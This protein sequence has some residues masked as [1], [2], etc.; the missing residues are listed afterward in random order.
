MAAIPK[1]EKATFFIFRTTLIM[2]TSVTKFK[3]DIFDIWYFIIFH[4][5]V[6]P[7]NFTIKAG[8]LLLLC[9]YYFCT[10][11]TNKINVEGKVSI[12]FVSL[13]FF[14]QAECLVSQGFIQAL[15]LT[16][17]FH[18]GLSFMAIAITQCVSARWPLQLWV[19]MGRCKPPF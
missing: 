16:S 2:D 4:C 13:R 15:S 18:E 6:F 5:F 11:K 7:D 14:F 8:G 17:V 9:I 12:E 1:E 10:D 19:H 3:V